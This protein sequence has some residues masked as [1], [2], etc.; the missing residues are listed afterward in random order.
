MA[1][2]A[3]TALRLVVSLLLSPGQVVFAGFVPGTAAGIVLDTVVGT[4]DM[5]SRQSLLPAMEEAVGL[6]TSP[7][8]TARLVMADSDMFREHILRRM[9]VG[10]CMFQEQMPH[11]VGVARLVAFGLVQ[12]VVQTAYRAPAHPAEAFSPVHL[13]AGLAAL[14]AAPFARNR[15]PFFLLYL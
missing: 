12:L 11:P 6:D 9:E 10:S 1:F 4:V 15:N 3:E 8:Q 7:E 14:A 2:A 5:P 13:R